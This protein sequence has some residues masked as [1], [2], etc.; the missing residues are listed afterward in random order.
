MLRL[1]IAAVLA[2]VLAYGFF[3]A[4]PLLLGPRITLDSPVEGYSSPDGTVTVSGTAYRSNALT[5]DGAP[6]L[7]DESG[8]F[9]AVLTLPSGGA[10]LSLTATDRF[11]R[12]RTVERDV[13]VH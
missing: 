2:A 13:V 9:S 3:E 4:R 5:L 12:T 6:L 11:G 10:I 1:A 8:R 7:M